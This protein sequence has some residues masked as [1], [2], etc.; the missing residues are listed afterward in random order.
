MSDGS[1]VQVNVSPGG[2]PKHPV[3]A[4]RVTSAGVEGD[5][6]REVTVHGGPH[7]A[8]SLLGIEA[9]Q[10]VAAEGHPIGPGTTGENLTVAGFDVSALPLGTRLRVG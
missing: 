9:I 1:V 4:A 6:Q 10:R 3:E 2:V 7:R 8:V 5:R